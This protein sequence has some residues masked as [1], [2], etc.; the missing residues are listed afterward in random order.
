M[1]I[2]ECYGICNWYFEYGSYLVLFDYFLEFINL[3]LV[4]KIFK[5]ISIDDKWC[6]VI[7]GEK[8]FKIDLVIYYIV[9]DLKFYI[10]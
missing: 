7:Y 1:E 10:G 5:C 2:I 6:L 3:K 4:G 9:L 8:I